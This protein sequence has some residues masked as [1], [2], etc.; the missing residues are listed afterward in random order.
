MHAS[1]VHRY[2]GNLAE[3]KLRWQIRVILFDEWSFAKLKALSRLIVFNNVEFLFFFLVSF[4][5]FSE[6]LG[7]TFS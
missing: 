1:N 6:I 5:K 3:L 7:D 2:A 4:S